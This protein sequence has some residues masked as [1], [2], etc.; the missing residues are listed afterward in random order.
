MKTKLL[1][2]I[3]LFISLSVTAQE[4]YKATTTSAVRLFSDKDDLTS[5]ITIIPTG[6]LVEVSKNDGEYL[7]VN[8]EDYQGYIAVG[9]V[10]FGQ[11]EEAVAEEQMPVETTVQKRQAPASRYD[12]LMMKYGAPIGKLLYEHKIWKGLSTENVTDSWGK[13][14][15][16][17]RT[18][19]DND[20]IEEWVYSKKWLMF[21]NDILVSWGDNR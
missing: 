6:S 16:M 17:N 1:F 5:V 2:V 10:I 13:P 8:F 3:A 15:R 4:S 19:N 9:T 14:A 18:Y 12:R 21:K 20:V 7:F 11:A